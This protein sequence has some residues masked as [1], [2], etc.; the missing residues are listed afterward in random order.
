MASSLPRVAVA[1]GR[2]AARDL[3]VAEVAR[4]LD[5]PPGVVVLAHECRRCGSDEH[6]RPRVL[7]TA[8]VRRPPHVSLSRAGSLSLVAVS[9]AGPVGVDVE[10]HGAADV[11]G[12]DVMLHPDERSLA[13]VDPTRTWVRTEALL[14]AY[15]LGL[16]VDPA[17]VRIDGRGLVSWSSP[18]PAPG[19]VLLRDVDVPGHVAAVVLIPHGDGTRMDLSV[20]QV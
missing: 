18:H 16:A 2:V 9:D 4:F 19:M 13:R 12:L 20:R 15:G 10:T 17:D 3:L 14:K 11:P 7:P 1:H 6:G 5:V 8:A